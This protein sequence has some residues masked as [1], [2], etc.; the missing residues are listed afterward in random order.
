MSK[1]RAGTASHVGR[2]GRCAS[3]SAASAPTV[4]LANTCRTRRPALTAQRVLI[5]TIIFIIIPK[6]QFVIGSYSPGLTTVCPLCPFGKYSRASASVCLSCTAGRYASIEG[7][8]TC[9]DCTPGK[10]AAEETTK[11]CSDC[12]AGRASSAFA[13]TV[14]DQCAIGRYTSLPAQLTCLNCTAGL[15]TNNTAGAVGCVDIAE[16]AS[17]PCANGGTCDHGT[18]LDLFRCSCPSGYA[19]LRCE[20]DIDEVIV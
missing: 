19:G 17:S 10:Y 7:A 12:H 14:C 1:R 2:V 18:S 8:T 11:R 13:A 4:L 3:I 6:T 5:V 15:S 16:C 20:T 9:S